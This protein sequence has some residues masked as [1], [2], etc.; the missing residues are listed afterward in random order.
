MAQM[1]PGHRVASCGHAVIPGRAPAIYRRAETGQHF[2]GGVRSCGA[3]WVCPYCAVRVGAHRAEE[4]RRGI[5]AARKRGLSVT[6]LT[7]TAQHYRHQRLPWLLGAA[8]RAHRRM[9][10]SRAWRSWAAR[11]GYTG[12]VRNLEV[13]YGAGT[14]WHPHIHALWFSEHA[15]SPALIRD[16]RIL[17]SAAAEKEGLYTDS[18]AGLVASNAPARIEGYLNKL[19]KQSW[20]GPEELTL[21]ALKKAREGQR[22]SPFDLARAYQSAA[23]ADQAKYY[24]RLWGTYLR[25]FKRHKQLFWSRGLRALLGLQKELTDAQAANLEQSEAAPIFTFS[26]RIWGHLRAGMTRLRLLEAVDT[27]GLEG[28]VLLLRSI[29]GTDWDTGGGDWAPG[30]AWGTP[31]DRIGA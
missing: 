22:L 26:R 19:G 8:T 17:Y 7:F 10:G 31:S 20:A 5:T 11:A 4:L 9:R 25:A 2:F 6:L 16:L 18:A 12:S 30:L 1:T 24:R 28:L 27:G 3:V 21:S 14:G 29:L 15:L 13:T 23:D